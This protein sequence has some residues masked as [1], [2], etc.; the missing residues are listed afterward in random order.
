MKELD[1]I[2]FCFSPGVGNISSFENDMSL[3][4]IKSF[5]A[6]YSVD[7]DSSKNSLIDFEKKFLPTLKFQ[8]C[9]SNL[10]FFQ[11]FSC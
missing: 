8:F 10:E 9:I 3:K 11:F 2:N 6:D 4:K 1:G 5:L 7:Y